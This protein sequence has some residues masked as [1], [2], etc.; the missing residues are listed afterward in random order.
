M[1][2]FCAVPWNELYI[3]SNGTYGMCC[4]EDQD[5]NDH[6]ISVE[7][8][9]EFHW[10]SD[11]LKKTRLD[12]VNGQNLPQC[13]HCWQEEEAGKVSGRMRR[14]Q[15]Y[16]G[17]ANLYTDDPLLTD[18]LS[19]TMADGSTTKEIE[20]LFFGV[21]DLC[22]L[23]CIDCSPSYSRSIL[24]DY[25]KLGWRVND[26]SR[27]SIRIQDLSHD[28]E[29]HNQYLWQ[30][31]REAG[32]SVRWIRVSGGEPTLSKELLSFL[33]WYAE[34]GHAD[35]TTIFIA[36]N[37]VNVKDEFIDALKPFQG[38]K[39][40]LSVDGLGALDEYLR[41]PTNWS[42]KVD[43]MDRLIETFPGCVV[44]TT[45]YSLNVGGLEKLIP[46]VET[47]DVL[48]SI[49]CLTYPEE[50]D[51]RHLPDSYKNEM[52]SMLEPWASNSEYKVSN[53][54]RQGDYRGNCINGVIGRLEQARD[55]KSWD[56]AKSIVKSYDT[57][58][59][60]RLSKILPS[61]SNYL[62]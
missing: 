5:A 47:K 9:I 44:H 8:P 50:L 40:E 20:G 53:D 2:R 23:R 22:Q 36:T 6:R 15:Q 25:Q 52:I 26:K 12:F 35:H 56:K 54:Y 7:Q 14:N 11:Y 18:T 10:N 62:D 27:R 61:L 41:Y 39:L 34:Q 31:V 38:V 19:K 55:E 13:R 21:G 49:Q 45:A 37:A 43:I 29:K 48:H 3:T 51:P 57:I 32:N 60:M 33:R 42:K 1:N 30:R 17:K 46:W 24:K 16:Y 28:P 59:P 58:R 4:M